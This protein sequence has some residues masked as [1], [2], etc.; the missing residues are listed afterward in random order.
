MAPI[1]Y[2][3]L[4]GVA[5]ILFVACSNSASGDSWL[6]APNGSP[7]DI[8]MWDQVTLNTATYFPRSQFFR[9]QKQITFGKNCSAEVFHLSDGTCK[10]FF[11]FLFSEDVDGTVNYYLTIPF[12]GIKC[13]N[14]DGRVSIDSDW[15]KTTVIY[16]FYHFG[17][18]GEEEKNESWMRI[19]GS[20]FI[21]NLDPQTVNDKWVET[22]LDLY[23]VTGSELAHFKDYSLVFPITCSE[24]GL[25]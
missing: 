5:T 8:K 15:I 7:V 12:E 25:E 21:D 1:K 2:S 4:V 22:D 9:P 10:G 23:L 11:S 24:P 3:I 13:E 17:K 16:S 14:G 20:I 18:G 19:S 6:Q